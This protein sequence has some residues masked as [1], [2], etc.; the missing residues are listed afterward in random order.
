I[1]KHYIAVRVDQDSRPD[2]ANRYEEYGWPATIVF[3]GDGGEIVKRRGYIPP[4]PMASLLQAIVD[5]PSPG[6]SVQ[7]EPVVV[8]A[9]EGALSDAQRD[10]M[11]ALF[12]DAYDDARGGW[13]G[14]HKYLN[15]DAIE[16]CLTLGAAG[17][18][19]MEKRA[20]QT[21]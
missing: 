20:R 4:R 3:N 17:D 19:S 5:D 21:L 12:L 8:P 9:K 13:G 16:Y 10:A 18:R 1:Q 2:L 11:R 15:W 14:V 7:P 6:P